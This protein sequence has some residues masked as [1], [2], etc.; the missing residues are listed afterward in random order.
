MDVWVGIIAILVGVVSCF[1]GY[2][3]FRMLLILAGLIGG[4]AFGQFLVQAGHP[5]LSLGMG[6]I[7]AVIMAVLA[8]PLWSIGFTI[9]GALVGFALLGEVSISLNIS[10]G[11]TLL[12][13]LMGAAAFGT[14]FYHLKDFLVILTTALKGATEV[15]FGLGWLMPGLAFRPGKVSWVMLVIIVLLGAAGFAVQYSMF[16]DRRTYSHR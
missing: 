10:P 13:G 5:W 1:Y 15:A 2:P 8:Y 11:M 7:T 3:L 4:Y 12:C 16:K 9:A 14:L 6:V